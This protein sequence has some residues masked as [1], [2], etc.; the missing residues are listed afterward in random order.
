MK[1][2]E[3][4]DA[5]LESV[6]RVTGTPIR[7]Y[8]MPMQLKEM[9]EAMRKIMADSYLAGSNDARKAA[10]DEIKEILSGEPH[11]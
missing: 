7:A 3:K 8:T 4:I 10:S 5:A 6:L 9:R 1:P 11:H 2:T